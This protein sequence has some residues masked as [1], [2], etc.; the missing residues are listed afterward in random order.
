[1]DIELEQ[2]SRRVG[3]AL[4]QR[5][6]MLGTAESCTGGWIAEVVTATAGS[7]NWFDRGFVTY[8]NAAKIDLLGVAEL[9]L[10]TRGAVSEQT[11][12]EMVRGALA[13]STA[14]IVVAVSGVAG[15][16]GGS[17]DKPVGTVCVGW[18]LRAGDVTTTTLH[19]GGDRESVRRQTVVAALEQVIRLSDAGGSISASSVP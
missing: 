12:A 8:S 1:M 19:F 15:P 6:W 11:V 5:G 18:G 16:G 3:T 13:H 17:A 9:T 4:E 7:S 10:V 14:Q 2:L